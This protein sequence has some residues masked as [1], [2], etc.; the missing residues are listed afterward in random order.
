MKCELFAI[1]SF[2]SYK[3][4]TQQMSVCWLRSQHSSQSVFVFV[5]SGEHGLISRRWY[6]KWGVTG[7]LLRERQFTQFVLYLLATCY[8]AIAPAR[9]LYRSP[10]CGC[11]KDTKLD[12]ARDDSLAPQSAFATVTI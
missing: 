9:K 4:Q 8:I 7:Q 5:L 2:P 1:A 3:E 12:G 6:A 10:C 11:R